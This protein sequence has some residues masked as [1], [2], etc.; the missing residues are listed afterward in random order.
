LTEDIGVLLM[1][2]GTPRN[3]DEVGA[4]YTHI[5]HGRPPSP[6]QL[7]DLIRRYRAI[8]GVSPL[9]DI[10]QRQAEGLQ[11]LL[12][13]RSGHRTWRVYLGMRHAPPF[14]EDTVRA[15]QG[16]G[17]QTAVTTV[18]A[19][20]YSGM[21]VGAYQR[22]AEAAR[23]DRPHP[24]WLHVNHWHTHPT[25]IA[26][27]ANRVAAAL[28]TFPN[29]DNVTIVF[30]AHSLPERILQEGDPYPKQV[31]E[32]GEAV[33]RR[34][35]LRRFRLGWQSAGRTQERWL[36]PDIL[37]L[38]KRLAAEGVRDVLVCPV[39]FVSDHLEVL[40]DLDIEAK[41]C[42]QKLGIRFTRT[43]SLN[44][45]PDFLEALAEIILSRIDADADVEGGTAT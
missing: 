2:Y 34:L 22:A 32:T 18:L 6:E 27:V 45:S 40:Y 35:S 15:M 41:E 16:D 42:A 1:A 20:H 10:T 9:N 7:A 21:S 24:R 39:G 19:P 3:L 5:R 13:E 25:F 37:D 14:I 30:T 33:A 44:D 38:L 36:G 29:P 8:G 23:G 43:A 4:Y 31:R 12:N 17:I 28:Q 11:R 26:A